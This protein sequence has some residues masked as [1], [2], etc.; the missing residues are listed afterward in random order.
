MK[1]TFLFLLF[2]AILSATSGY[3]MSKAS[4]IGRV[5]ITFFHKEYNLLKIWW[6]GAIAVYMA[7]FLL[8]LL[9][10]YLHKKLSLLT[11]RLLDILMLCL[12]VAGLYFTYEDFHNNFTHR[13][14][15]H[16]FHYGCYLFWVGWMMICLFFVFKKRTA[17]T[18]SGST[19]PAN[20]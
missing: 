13:V 1:R 20:V 9:H 18:N 8:F 4:W 6:Q 7:L 3:L 17:I 2:L 11:A 19:D 12:T 15:G 16:R 10:S 5:G 14:L